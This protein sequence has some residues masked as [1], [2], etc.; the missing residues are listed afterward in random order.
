MTIRVSIGSAVERLAHAARSARADGREGDDLV[1][2]VGVDE[3]LEHAD[4]VVADAGARQGERRDVDDDAHRGQEAGRIGAAPSRARRTSAMPSRTRSTETCSALGQGVAWQDDLDLDR[5][6]RTRRRAAAAPGA[7]RSRS[8]P[9]ST[10]GPTITLPGR[11]ESLAAGPPAPAGV[12][13]REPEHRRRRPAPPASP[14][15]RSA[16][17]TAPAPR[18]R[19]CAPRSCSGP[20][21]GAGGEAGRAA[22]A[23]PPISN[24]SSTRAYRV[25][26]SKPA[27]SSTSTRYSGSNGDSSVP[28]CSISSIRWRSR[29]GA[30]RRPHAL[31]DVDPA[32]RHERRGGAPAAS[33]ARRRSGAS[34][35]RAPPAS[36]R[37]APRH[38]AHGHGVELGQRLL[39]AP[40]R[41]AAGCAR[42]ARRRSPPCP[43]RCRSPV[44]Q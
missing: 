32:A 27:C 30:G 11:T 38:L 20:G 1:A 33:P 37:P 25:I 18:R 17:G 21:S 7:A 4:R 22:S 23:S 10:Y 8:P 3:A 40:R 41:S 12:R 24:S 14:R 34:C 39:R 13:D 5:L 26:C 31:L 36:K 42:S 9:L 28:C 15:A 29:V 43:R 16:P 6:V 44:T 35:R 19:A 2:A